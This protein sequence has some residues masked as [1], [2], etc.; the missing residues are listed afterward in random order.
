M[1]Q[2]I[3]VLLT[4][5]HSV[6]RSG[7][8]RLL[9]QNEGIEVVAEAESGEQAYRLFNEHMPDVV[10]MDVSMPGMGGLSALR[11]ILARH[12]DAKIVI[13]SMHENATVATQALSSG[14]VAFVEKS[15]NAEDLVLAVKE[16]VAGRTF[17]SANLA[18]KIALQGISGENDPMQKLT[19]REFE[20]FHLLADGK[21]V[22]EIATSLNLS[23]K[24]VANYQTLL[25]QKLE[26]NSP[27]DLVRL[28]LKYG[29]IEE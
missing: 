1:I 26:L 18:Q 25:K 7:V 5:D 29:I 16:V 6:V 27:V 20:I 17:L 14:A 22:D 12:R 2:S 21:A 24:T 9:E 19:S 13:F 11:R 8:R 4:D 3:R 23:Q 10:I 28:A 15:G